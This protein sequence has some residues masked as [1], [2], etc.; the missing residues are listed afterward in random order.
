MLEH[1]E[2]SLN[3]LSD[4]LT[5][6]HRLATWNLF[7]LP[8]AWG[9]ALEVTEAEVASLPMQAMQLP[10]HRVHYLDYEG[11][12]SNGRGNVRSITAG[13]FNWIEATATRFEAE[14]LAPSPLAG[15]LLLTLTDAAGKNVVDSELVGS[16][17]DDSIADSNTVANS[18]LRSSEEKLPT[19]AAW[20]L[21]WS[22]A[23]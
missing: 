16:A 1:N 9:K 22:P 4:G 8:F 13:D 5:Q 21:E 23:R 10:N 17:A 3:A 12:V 18:A 19:N 11:P 15:R 7:Q 20:I 2:D 6:E 14:L